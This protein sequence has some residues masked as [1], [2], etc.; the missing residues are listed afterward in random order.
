MMKKFIFLLV[1]LMTVVAVLP[2]HA[3]GSGPRVMDTT[4]PVPAYIKAAID[5][6]L[7][8]NPP[9]DGTDNYVITY[10]HAT[11]AG[12]VVS[13]AAIENLE[14]WYIDDALWWGS[15]RVVLNNDGIWNAEYTL[16]PTGAKMAA[17]R[18]AAGGGSYVR[19][20]FQTGK[21]AMYGTRGA[22]G[23]GFGTPNAKAVDWVSGADYGSNAANDSVYASDAGVIDQVC[24]DGTT[25]AIRTL[26]SSTGDYF[27]YLHLKA[28]SSLEI[29][30]SFSRGSTIGTLRHGKFNDNCGWADQAD[31]HWH[32]HWGFVPAGGAFQAEGCILT[33]S[34]NKWD[35][36]GHNVSPGEW[37]MSDGGGS[38][39]G[40]D[41]PGSGPPSGFFDYLINGG[42]SFM[43]TVFVS[44]LVTHNDDAY[45]A[46]VLGNGIIVV[47]VITY[48]LLKGS[49]DLWPVL[50]V[51]LAILI[52]ETAR[53]VINSIPL[54][55]RLIKLIP[56]L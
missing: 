3:Q 24:T 36:G 16:A 37:T 23:A 28:N 41:D 19:F 47:F 39:G 27:I 29:D 55:L 11:D 50:Y 15:M 26:N 53:L 38:D 8:T 49:V 18:M 30:Q 21:S 45:I 25:V 35:C 33:V 22:H 54:I 2:V 10:T 13:V 20:P 32:V 4:L 48:V 12:W 51:I 7:A 56:F 5:D 44:K 14:N 1:A 31:N 42:I 43:E 46:T 6:L 34:S 40:T 17:P 52:L 9:I